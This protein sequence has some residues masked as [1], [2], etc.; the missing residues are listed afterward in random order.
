MPST[1]LFDGTN[2]LFDP[3]IFDTVIRNTVDIVE[4][5]TVF[6]SAIFDSVIFDTASGGA[7]T[8]DDLLARVQNLN[9][10]LSESTSVGAGTITK[11]I[12]KAIAET[13]TTISD[14]LSR[15]LVS[16]RSLTE[17]ETIGVGTITTLRPTSVRNIYDLGALFDS[18]YFS[19]PPFDLTV[20]SY[21]ITDSVSRG[22]NSTRTI[23]E[24]AISIGVGA[25]T[26]LLGATRS[27]SESITVGAGTI[28][29]QISKSLSESVTIGV[30]T[31]SRTRL[32][33]RALLE[34]ISLSDSVTRTY[35][36]LRTIS[37]SVSVGVGTIGKAISKS[38]T[39]STITIGDSVSRSIAFLRTILNSVTVLAGTVTGGWGTARIATA[40]ITKRAGDSSITKRTA[41]V[42]VTELN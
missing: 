28:V 11:Q 33:T 13:A 1:T 19:D 12:A 8:V 5:Q 30:G 15:L 25:V 24:S 35:N 26:R 17:S 4:K 38:I 22:L 6:D 21:P 42:K 40:Y 23:T 9:T 41:D 32:I 36:P 16:L 3:V 39:E 10:A 14:S 29:K 18:V 7:I 37:D 2:N 34:A 31:I 27:I 20:N